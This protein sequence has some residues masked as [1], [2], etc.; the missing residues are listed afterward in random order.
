MR[1]AVINEVIN[2]V[3]DFVI[4]T[5]RYSLELMDKGLINI[6]GQNWAVSCSKFGM[7]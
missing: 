1:G 6:E 4:P 3:A 5:D 7:R 2:T